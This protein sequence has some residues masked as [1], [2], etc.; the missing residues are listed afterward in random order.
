MIRKRCWDVRANKYLKIAK[1][2]ATNYWQMLGGYLILIRTT[3]QSIWGKYLILV[4]NV[5]Y[6][7]LVKF[8]IRMSPIKA[9]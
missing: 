4:T 1:T 2:I 5:N 6:M 7:F 3:Y 9:N 8:I